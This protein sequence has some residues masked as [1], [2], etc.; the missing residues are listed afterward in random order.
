MLR[1]SRQHGLK[2]RHD[3]SVPGVGV[4]SNAHCFQALMFIR[5]SVCT[6]P[7]L[8]KPEQH[9]AWPPH[10]PSARD[11]HLMDHA[12]RRQD[13]ARRAPRDERL[14]DRGGAWRVAGARCNASHAIFARR[15]A[16]IGRL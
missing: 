16:V 12:V 9:S 10:R 11:P 15:P 14:L 8:G 2:A 1:I 5:D 4:P 6:S 7:S 13:N 3:L